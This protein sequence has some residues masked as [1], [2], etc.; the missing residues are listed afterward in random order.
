MK[1]RPILLDTQVFSIIDLQSMHL[2]ERGRQGRKEEGITGGEKGRGESGNKRGA[3]LAVVPV[4]IVIY[5]C[6]LPFETGLFCFLFCF[7]FFKFLFERD[8]KSWGGEEREREREREYQ[9]DSMLPAAEPSM[10][11]EL[12]IL[13]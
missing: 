9:T 2:K 11:L 1:F 3:D 5:F 13:T 6:G 7:S 8:S 12:E 4:F 10:G